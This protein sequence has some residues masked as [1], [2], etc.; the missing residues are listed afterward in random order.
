MLAQIPRS[1]L[2]VF[3]ALLCPTLSRADWPF[4]PNVNVP[5]CTAASEQTNPS[6]VPDGAGGA[7]IA[8][9]DSRG[10]SGFDIYA[11]RVNAAGFPLWT[12]NGVAVCT[13]SGDQTVPVAVAD[14]QGG[15]VVAWMDN[16]HN[17]SD[18]YAQRIDASGATQWAAGG[19]ALCTAIYDQF[20]LHA[21][22][23]GA[24]GAIASW[25][26]FR[27]STYEVYA[28]RV[29]A[30]GHTHWNT[31]GVKLSPDYSA[32]LMGGL[33]ADGSGGAI[34]TWA[35]PYGHLY[36]QHV[37]SAANLLWPA[38]GVLL[39][40]R[41]ATYLSTVAP[42]GLGGAVLAWSDGQS[43]FAQRLDPLG[44][45]AWTV[46]GVLIGSTFATAPGA[47]PDGAG[48]EIVTFSTGTGFI[49]AQRMGAGG[50]AQWLPG[51]VDLAPVPG[52]IYSQTISDGLGGAIVAW[53]DARN[54]TVPG[55]TS[56]IRTQFDDVF[57]QRV[58]GAGEVAWNPNGVPVCTAPERQAFPTLIARGDGGAIVAWND[59][60]SG[61]GDIYA[62]LVNP[63][64]TLGDSP[65]ATLASLVS[66]DAFDD[67]AVLRWFDPQSSDAIIYRADEAN[68]WRE[69][70]RVAPD[71][72][73]VVQYVDHSVTPGR[74]YGYR[75][76]VELQ[77]SIALAGEVWVS[78][79]VTATFSLSK[80]NPNPT[81]GGM[82]V[83]FSLPTN[84]P[85]W[86]EV[87]DPSGRRVES[88]PV[89]TLGA[90]THEVGMDLQ[91]GLRTP[92]VYQL[93][94]TQGNHRA[95]ARAVLIR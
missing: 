53:T 37:N 20:M 4:D 67:R 2:A 35:S 57:A 18:I 94:L 73:H 31:D 54:D 13:A 60:R 78:V 11:Q 19:V 15:A 93:L 58:T 87:F 77:G 25:T 95:S 59:D 64:G 45:P 8:W 62:Q 16:R 82:T 83:T 85:A 26:D 80:T 74:R 34:L 47:V 28:Q 10:G 69:V 72:S 1:T 84:E 21:V 6:I 52:Q 23:D 32:A 65:V 41:A 44:A 88:I 89:G 71:G 22:S 36:A 17:D 86:L 49:K 7:I 5:V 3:V 12:A 90:G 56:S 50:D 29:D 66:A 33:A 24:S 38:N 9:Q 51:G 55:D 48:G 68:S 91:S 46:G 40:A 81:T 27:A 75:L 76:G 30:F 42:D 70:S 61:G 39:D 43:A 92:G 63:D 79:P 14:G